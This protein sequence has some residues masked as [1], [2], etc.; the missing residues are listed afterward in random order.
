LF[1]LLDEVWKKFVPAAQKKN[2]GF[3]LVKSPSSENIQ[4]TADY[5]L[6]R[7]ALSHLVD[8]A[9]KFTKQGSVSIGAEV[10][11]HD[12]EFFVKDTGIG[13]GQESHALVFEQF[14][15]ENSSNTRGFEGSGLGLTIAKKIVELCGGRIWFHSVQGQGS[16]FYLSIPIALPDEEKKDEN[17]LSAQTEVPQPGKLKVL[18]AEDVEASEQYLT[19]ALRKITSEIIYAATGPEAVEACKNNPDLDLILMDIKMPEMNGNDATSLIR[20]FNKTVIIIAQ[21]AYAELGDRE[22]AMEAGC[23]DFIAKPI[24]QGI[25]IEKIAKY[26][27]I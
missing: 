20:Q 1:N 15:Q 6:L 27:K 4:V 16:E 5:N 26:F 7:K 3:E 24:S 18:I 8:N 19:L 10:K 17:E 23:N 21:T 12:L 2:I 13:I 9:V 22:K 25:L 11:E 14:V